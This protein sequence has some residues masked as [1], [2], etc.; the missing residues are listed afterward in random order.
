MKSFLDFSL[1]CSTHAPIW[2]SFCLFLLQRTLLLGPSAP[3]FVHKHFQ[4]PFLCVSR[5]PLI[6]FQNFSIYYQMFTLLTR[7]IPSLKT[8]GYFKARYQTGSDVYE[9]LVS[10]ESPIFNGQY[11]NTDSK[12]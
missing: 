9:S 10:F 12:T 2:L 1:V 8:R 11:E 4:F 3:E 6:A 5:S 7:G